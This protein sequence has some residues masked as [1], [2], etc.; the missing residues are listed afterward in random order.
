MEGGL[1]MEN[2]ESVKQNLFKPVET[3]RASQAVFEQ[4]EH[5][6]LTRKIEKGEK[7]PSERQLMQIFHKSHPT[8]REALRMLESAGYIQVIP[9]GAS[10]VCYSNTKIMKENLAELM[11]F[12]KVPVQDIIGF[13][14][15]TEKEFL[16][17]TLKN[18]TWEDQ[19]ALEACLNVMEKHMDDSGVY[20]TYM[21]AFHKNLLK[22]SHNPLIFV[23]GEAFFEYMENQK[24]TGEAVIAGKEEMT[25]LQKQHALVIKA[26]RDKDEQRMGDTLDGIWSLLDRR[27]CHE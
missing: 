5:L 21:M 24:L 18:T 22:A 17:D 11:Q 9:G 13:M 23:I 14:A 25:L 20:L 6:I 27:N 16:R 26:F 10:V 4:I 3:T 2:T 12:K 19:M 1:R 15:E 7:L 8:I